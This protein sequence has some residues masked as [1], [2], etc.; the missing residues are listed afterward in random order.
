MKKDECEKAIRARC[1]D[2]AQ[3]LSE[4]EMKDPS[5]SAFKQ[6]LS[7]K[8]FSNYLDFRATPTADYVAELWVAEELKQLWRY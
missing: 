5:F 1:H 7:D 8:G 3:G 4:D 2:W 6:W